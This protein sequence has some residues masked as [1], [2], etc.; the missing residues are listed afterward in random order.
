MGWSLQP[1]TFLPLSLRSRL[2][3]EQSYACDCVIMGLD[4]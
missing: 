2:G 1:G 3:E 4:F